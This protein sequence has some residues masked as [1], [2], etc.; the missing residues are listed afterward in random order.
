MYQ[1][2][3]HKKLKPVNTLEVLHD[4]LNMIILMADEC[5]LLK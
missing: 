5:N 2:I 4:H 3:A 1:L